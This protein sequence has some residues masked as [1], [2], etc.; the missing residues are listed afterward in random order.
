MGKVFH[1]QISLLITP[2]ETTKIVL[3]P[4]CPD[5]RPG[6]GLLVMVL[7]WL[8]SCL[9]SEV[10]GQGLVP[11]QARATRTSHWSFPGPEAHEEAK[12]C[13]EGF[14]SKWPQV[15]AQSLACAVAT[16]TQVNCLGC[17]YQICL[18]GTGQCHLASEVAMVF[19]EHL[20]SCHREPS[21]TGRQNPM[22]MGEL[23][24]NQSCDELVVKPG[25]HF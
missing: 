11:L 12:S 21:K 5:A 17:P 10:R 3:H 20:M 24:L 8:V 16:H 18:C 19:H 4:K 7:M 2:Q 15:E 9:E 6:Q 25:P 14:Y 22:A 13:G 1:L 23:A